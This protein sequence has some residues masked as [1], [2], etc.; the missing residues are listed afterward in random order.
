MSTQELGRYESL[1]QKRFPIQLA[2]S[3]TD[4]AAVTS[5]RTLLCDSFTPEQP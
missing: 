4:L 1:T 2:D 5:V 3:I